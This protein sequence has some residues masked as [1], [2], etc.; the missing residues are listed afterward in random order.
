MGKGVWSHYGYLK[1]F[2][3]IT[4]FFSYFVLTQKM[5][6]VKT[7]RSHIG[8]DSGPLHLEMYTGLR[9]GCTI[10]HQTPSRP[11]LTLAGGIVIQNEIT[12]K[13]THDALVLG[14]T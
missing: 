5:R 10:I 1:A 6:K 12:R 14:V 9:N 2:L 3:I 11:T 8:C 4:P 7:D 13:S